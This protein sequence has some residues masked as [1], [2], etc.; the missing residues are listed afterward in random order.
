MD[1][2]ARVMGGKGKWRATHAAAVSGCSARGHG[3][4]DALAAVLIVG[5]HGGD[6]F[7]SECWYE[8]T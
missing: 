1:G 7:G 3:A 5:G 8:V 6:G 2:G 4:D